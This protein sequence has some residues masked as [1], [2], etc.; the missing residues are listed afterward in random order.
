MIE[1]LSKSHDNVLGI[2]ASGKVTAVDYE[3]VLIPKVNDL[4]SEHATG[5]FLYYLSDE[6]EGFE[7]G[8]LWDDAKYASA[9]SDQFDKV[10][11]VGG[12]KWVQWTT[13]L[14][15][16]FIKA[17]VKKFNKNQLDEAWNWIES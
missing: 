7:L 3:K 10:A 8:A 11:I 13:K 6:F 16:L 4:L 14:A 5:R 12:P 9:H 15:G 17:E 1:V 2:K